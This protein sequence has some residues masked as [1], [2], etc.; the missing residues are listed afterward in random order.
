MSKTT[1]RLRKSGQFSLT[2]EDPNP[3]GSSVAPPPAYTP[4]LD[5]TEGPDNEPVNITAA[6]EKLSLA[7]PTPSYFPTAD[8]C[9]AHLKL[10][11]A[12][13]SLKE[14]VGY[15]DGLWGLWDSR[16]GPINH[17]ERS[18]EERAKDPQLRVLS[19]IREKRWALFVARAVDRYEAWWRSFP[20]QPLSEGDMLA[21]ASDKYINFTNDGNPPLIPWSE[22]MLPPLDVLMV[23]HTHMLNPRSF[24]ED[25][26][27]AGFRALWH[28]GMPWDLIHKAIDTDFAYNVSDDGKALWCAKTGLSWEN[29]DDP[30]IKPMKCPRCSIPI[31]V[32]WTTCGIPE[33]V[34]SD[35]VP[36]LTGNGYGD[37]NLQYRC[38][39]CFIV[40]C[41]ELLSVAKFVADTWALLAPVSRPMP[42]TILSPTTGKPETAPTDDVSRARVPRTF[43]NRLLKSGW[44][45]IRTKVI[46]TITSGRIAQPTMHNIKSDIEGIFRERDSIRYID[47][48]LTVPTSGKY[49]L[50]P[51]ARI[52][53]RKM[54]SR[55][56]ENFSPFALDLSGAVMRQGVFVEKMYRL[57]WLHSPSARDTMDRLRTK[58]N[59]FIEIMAANPNKVA[60]PTLDVDLA[61]HTHQLS[62]SAY[63]QFVVSR[64]ARFIDHDDK[65]DEN[66]LDRHF[67][68]T[69]K[70]Y[71][72]RYGEVY[73][74]CTCWYC[75]SIRSTL[76]NP[77]G[78]ILGISNQEKVSESFH[79]SGA[80]KLC[81]PSNSAHISSHNSVKAHHD[82]M[83]PT[84]LSRMVQR[85]MAELQRKRL[86][87]AYAKAQKRAAKKGRTIPPRKDYYDHWGYPFAVYG[88]FAYAMWW[89]PGMYYG[90][91]PGYI[92][93]CGGGS[94]GACANGTCGGGVAAGA[95]GTPGVS[96][97]P[98]CWVYA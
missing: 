94:T 66:A 45:Q 25:T 11:F 96:T 59:R 72:D 46:E 79:A 28:T 6:F 50:N 90:A 4:Q 34:T 24:L 27:L 1:S 3:S 20:G 8:A 87:A 62:P 98:V 9:L 68:W 47:S 67:E 32:P 60:V 77:M 49:R 95:C 80:A 13:Q 43:P 75:E 7:N 17:S 64:T 69:S 15:T 81:P 53:I 22:E 41:K 97:Y 74:E 29:V 58:Y 76:I 54:M 82:P 71:Q 86:D 18:V 31:Q 12:L 78:K 14:D 57:D 30:L 51:V 73:S 85:Q 37:G 40:I 55:Y 5:A 26:M 48:V 23:W 70:E 61:W 89:T 2:T 88:A 56:W 44:N 52:C 93:A 33:D 38:P 65:I 42:G 16:A 10:L 63:Y 92:A 21:T 84:S 39:K 83:A 35:G 19:Q 91:Y 36:D